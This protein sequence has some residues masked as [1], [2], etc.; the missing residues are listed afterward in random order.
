MNGARSEQRCAT[1]SPNNVRRNDMAGGIT[2]L[3]LD[4]ACLEDERM[5][6]HGFTDGR[7]RYCIL[8]IYPALR[9]STYLQIVM[10]LLQGHGHRHRFLS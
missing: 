1:L 9:P 2:Y 6:V 5:A 4:G 3:P 10:I 7:T 8:L